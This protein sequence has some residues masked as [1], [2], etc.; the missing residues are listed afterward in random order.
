MIISHF[1]QLSKAFFHY[2]GKQAAKGII[3][4][5]TGYYVQRTM[6]KRRG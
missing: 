1:G 4:T 3:W 2:T 6:P 5:L